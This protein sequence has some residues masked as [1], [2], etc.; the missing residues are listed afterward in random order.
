[1]GTRY[2]A[3]IGIFAPAQFL[4]GEQILQRKVLLN[5]CCEH[6]KTHSPGLLAG[7]TFAVLIAPGLGWAQGE[8][9]VVCALTGGFHDGDTFACTGF[10]QP[11]KVRV[12]GIDAP[13][14]GQGFWRVS[15]DLLRTRAVAGTVAIFV[16]ALKKIENL[17]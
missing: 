14:V 11:Y 16:R 13:E 1:M 2:H 6:Q 17:P 8:G 5:R 15:R 9:D 7:Y 3:T 10:E 12:A 4:A